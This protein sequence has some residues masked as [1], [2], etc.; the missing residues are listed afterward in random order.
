MRWAAAFNEQRA[1]AQT[2]ATFYDGRDVLLDL[3]A[4]W[5]VATTYLNG[6]GIDNHLRQ[7]NSTTGIG[8]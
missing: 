5:S 6:P 4:D 7:T 2:S 8:P 1:R 3:S